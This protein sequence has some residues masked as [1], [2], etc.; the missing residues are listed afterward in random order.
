MVKILTFLRAIYFWYLYAIFWKFLVIYLVIT[1]NL[2]ILNI[3]LTKKFIFNGTKIVGAPRIF[4]KI[5]TV[6]WKSSAKANT[7]ILSQEYLGC[8][9]VLLSHF[10]TPF[11]PIWLSF[12]CVIW[13][14]TMFSCILFDVEYPFILFPIVFIICFFL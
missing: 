3:M 2:N 8:F 11:H 12:W 14:L 13:L 1:T 10:E 7:V 5:Y 4:S 6:I 9:S